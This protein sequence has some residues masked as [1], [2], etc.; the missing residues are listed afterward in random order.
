MSF[1]F[2]YRHKKDIPLI[3]L[4]THKKTYILFGLLLIIFIIA[5]FVVLAGF[6]FK[7]FPAYVSGF[8]FAASHAGS[9]H[10]AYLFGEHSMDG[11]W[12]YYIAAFLIKTPIATLIFIL[13]SLILFNRIRNRDIVNELFLVIPIAVLLVFSFFNSI[14]IG[15]RHIL[16][17][18]P[19][20]FVFVS[21]IV[22]LKIKKQKIFSIIIVLLSLWYII[23]SL[24]IYPHYLA[25]FNEAV[26]GADNGHKYL[27]DSNI[28][29]GQDLKGLKI[30]LDERGIEDIKIGYWGQDTPD[31]IGINYQQLNCYAEPGLI[32]VS[33]NTLYGLR[34]EG[35]IV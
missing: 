17:I 19:F 27:L 13:L 25:Y 9:G 7:G 29:W 5:F 33:V 6:G 24:G 8:K 28:D 26:G 15:V 32:A 31:R 14:N 34:K 22:N 21:K 1:V 10:P 20:I 11:W 4:L 2:L 16:G 23:S 30:Y 18:Y 35:A 3:K 12:Y